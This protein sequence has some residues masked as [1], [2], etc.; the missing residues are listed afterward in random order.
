MKIDELNEIGFN[1]AKSEFLKCC[2]SEE[3]AKRMANS[4]PFE[5][6]ECLQEVAED[7]WEKKLKE[8][9]RLEAFSG[10][11]KIGDVNSLKAKYANTAAM[12]GHEQS[13]VDSASDETISELAR[14]N[15]EY[16]DKFGYIFIICATGKSADEMLEILKSR[17]GNTPEKEIEIAAVE[18]NKITQIRLNKVF[19]EE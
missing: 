7:I 16:E 2:T 18:Q 17:I 8:K 10:H 11:P 13:G 4:I 1:A 3:W 6:M 5:D 12:A 19:T 14:L 9:D 15:K